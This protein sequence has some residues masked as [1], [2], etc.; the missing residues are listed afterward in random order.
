[1]SNVVNSFIPLLI[2]SLISDSNL[3]EHWIYWQPCKIMEAM[4][5][6]IRGNI[7]KHIG[8]LEVNTKLIENGILFN[9]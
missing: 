4:M 8:M 2:I 5:T 7:I 1:M 9:H 3:T 6:Q